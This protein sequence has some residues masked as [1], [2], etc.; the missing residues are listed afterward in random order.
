M[1]IKKEVE[2]F[3]CD[4]PTCPHGELRIVPNLVTES[5][6]SPKEAVSDD[7]WYTIHQAREPK[8]TGANLDRLNFC[9][10]FC[11]SD[12][13]GY[14]LTIRQQQATM[15]LV[16]PLADVFEAVRLYSPEV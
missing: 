16:I 11:V 7:R 8:L 1:K 4:N 12:F 10:A 13:L 15:S 14:E 3:V 2:V 6:R 9:S 5:R